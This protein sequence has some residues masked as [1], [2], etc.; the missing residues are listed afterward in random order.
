M[1][2]SFYW[3]LAERD[4][5]DVKFVLPAAFVKGLAKALKALEC[6]SARSRERRFIIRGG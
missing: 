6:A 2:E 4:Y 1:G 3:S 5:L